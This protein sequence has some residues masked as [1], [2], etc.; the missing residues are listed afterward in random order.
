[1]AEVA[2]LL[3]QDLPTERPAMRA[4]GVAALAAHL[5]GDLTIEVAATRGKLDTRQY[6]K[7]QM[8]WLRGR[9]TGW[10]AIEANQPEQAAAEILRMRPT[11]SPAAPVRLRPSRGRS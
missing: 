3:A 10:T 1:M 11:P 7:R 5:T 6:A 2:S 4:T 8:T 9:M